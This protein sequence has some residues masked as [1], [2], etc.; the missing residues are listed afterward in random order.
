MLGPIIYYRIS[1]WLYSHRIPLLPRLIDIMVRC[2]FACWLPHS[3]KIGKNLVLGYG[4]LGVVIHSLCE[5]GEDVQ[6]DQGVTLGGNATSFGAPKIGSNV[7]IGAGAK[8]LGPVVVGQGTVIG[9]NAVVTRDIPPRS[10]AV[11]IPARVIKTDI[12]IDDFLHHKRGRSSK[13]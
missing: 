6:I 10:V 8:I 3:A 4:G 13:S 12:D 2:V 1:N 5:I 7:Y 9:A 11:G